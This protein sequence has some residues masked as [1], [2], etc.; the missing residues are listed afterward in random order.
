MPVVGLGGFFSLSFS[1]LL[2]L[3]IFL[4]KNIYRIFVGELRENILAQIFMEYL[5]I[6][7][8][9]SSDINIL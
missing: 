4:G 3:G 9:N 1:F 6:I 8:G 5:W 7:S 2:F